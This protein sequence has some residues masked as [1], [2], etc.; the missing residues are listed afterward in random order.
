[1]RAGADA[2]AVFAQLVRTPSAAGPRPATPFRPATPWTAAPPSR[3]TPKPRPG[4]KPGSPERAGRGATPRR[5]RSDEAGAG[6]GEGVPVGGLRHV[7]SLPA[8]GPPGEPVLAPARGTTSAGEPLLSPAR[9]IMTSRSDDSEGAGAAL[10]GHTP[11]GWNNTDSGIRAAG[12]GG[13]V[14]AKR[15]RWSD[16]ADEGAGPGSSEGLQAASPAR[17]ELR[18]YPLTAAM[19]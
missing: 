4:S 14:R 17:R 16:E 10:A 3:K 13:G 18:S 2:E 12:G 6:A 8:G 9:G 5:V 15:V 11:R 7:A 19:E 1:M